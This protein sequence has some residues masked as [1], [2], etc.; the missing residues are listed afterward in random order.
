MLQAGGV[1]P[2]WD[3]DGDALSEP[4]RGVGA[5]GLSTGTAALSILPLCTV[6]VQFICSDNRRR[7]YPE[8]RKLEY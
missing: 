8:G 6:P 2:H 7:V 3:E 4:H 1:H 5:G